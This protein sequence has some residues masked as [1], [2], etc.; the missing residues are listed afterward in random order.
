L[1]SSKFKYPVDFTPSLYF[2]NCYGIIVDPSTKA[3]TVR[4]KVAAGQANFFRS[5]P[6]HHSQKE[7][8]RNDEYSIFSY[9]LS[10]AFDFQ[11]E[12][13]S[14]G[15]NVEVLEPAWLRQEMADKI[16]TLHDIYNQ[17]TKGK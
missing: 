5:L 11:Q 8:E 2:N 17:N 15:D 4:L 10:A 13:F 14:Q 16:E 1:E 12:L 9:Y 3:E 6:L 7:E